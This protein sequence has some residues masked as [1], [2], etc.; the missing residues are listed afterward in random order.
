[1]VNSNTL[2]IIINSFFWLIDLC[3][4]LWIDL[5]EAPAIF[6]S[7]LTGIQEKFSLS[8]RC[9]DSL[10]SLKRDKLSCG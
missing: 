5:D 7:E 4:I 2:S 10:I 3:V 1:M 8:G 9:K 6:I